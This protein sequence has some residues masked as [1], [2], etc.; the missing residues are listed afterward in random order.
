MKHISKLLLGFALVFT[1]LF[2]TVGTS[3]VTGNE[4]FAADDCKVQ[5][6]GEKN[7]DA[8]S[9]NNGDVGTINEKI[10]TFVTIIS[11]LVFG[12]AILM[13][14]YAG[15]KYA[16]SQGEAKVTEQAKM[17]IVAAGIGIGISLLSFVLLNIFKT[18]LGGSSTTTTT[19][20]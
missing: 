9:C 15:F 18:V 5:K 12:V 10:Y 7:L 16:T 2:A 1:F 8:I 20:P 3:F 4:A 11:G 13:I 17:Q 14:V 19:T 6:L